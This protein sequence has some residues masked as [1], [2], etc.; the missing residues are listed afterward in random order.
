MLLG[1]PCC[2]LFSED[3]LTVGVVSALGREVRG[4]TG[5]ALRG[6]VQTDAAIN[7]GNSGGPLLDSGGRLIGVNTAIVSPS[8][9]SAGI[10]FA[11]PVDVSYRLCFFVFR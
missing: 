10:G 7:P 4:A 8:G 5:N 6:C 11:I 1:H 9:S 2:G 3:T